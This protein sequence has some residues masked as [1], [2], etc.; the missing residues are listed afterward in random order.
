M[1]LDERLTVIVAKNGAGKTTILDAIA[2]GLGQ[3]ITRLPK[4]SGINPKDSDYLLDNNGNK[5][6]YMRIAFESTR[7]IRWDRTEKR[8]QTQKTQSKIPKADG[9]KELNDYVDKLVDAYNDKSSFDLPIFANDKSSFDLPIFA[10]YG[11]GS[12]VFEV[13]QRRQN[14]KKMFSRFEA[15][16]GALEAKANFRRFFEYF[17]FLEELEH[18]GVQKEQDLNYQQ[19]ELKTIRKAIE[20]AM[21]MFKNPRSQ[22]RP[23]CFL[24]DWQINQEETKTLRIEQLSD[25]YRTTLAMIMDIAARM[26]SANPELKNP[27][28]TEGIILIDEVELHLHPGWQQTILPPLLETFPNVQFIVTTHSPQVLTTVPS[29]SIKAI[30]WDSSE[31]PNLMPSIEFSEG[32]E[33][34]QLLEDILGIKPRPQNIDIVKKLNRYLELISLDKWDSTEAKAL[35][36]KLDKWGQGYETA[37]ANADID[38]RLRLRRLGR[39]HE[40]NQ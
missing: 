27:L 40:E 10:Y 17:Y 8:D 4:V 11:T 2:I 18:Q 33:S 16:Q 37:L 15:L 13:P 32:A 20:S 30:Q 14:F 22:V 19:A 7:G 28:E 31:Q 3:F 38:I 36:S 12:G 34:Q 21:P 9:I 25:G 23:L 29:S 6:A 35:R 1:R 24:V 5:P 26:A 39:K